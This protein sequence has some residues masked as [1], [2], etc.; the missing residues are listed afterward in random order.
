M[1]K[2]SEQTAGITSVFVGEDNIVRLPTAGY[3]KSIKIYRNGSKSSLWCHSL[4]L[5][6]T[7]AE[8][9]EEEA[10]TIDRIASATAV[11]TVDFIF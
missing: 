10:C 11:R 5:E 2:K 6:C 1:V 8:N 3:G 7:C 4:R 9:P